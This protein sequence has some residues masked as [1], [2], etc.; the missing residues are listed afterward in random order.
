M[1]ELTRTEKNYMKRIRY[2]K[3]SWV[4]EMSVRR[5]IISITILFIL[6]SVMCYGSAKAAKSFSPAI[7]LLLTNGPYITFGPYVLGITDSTITLSVTMNENGTGYYLIRSTLETKPTVSQVMAGTYFHMTADMAAAQ[8]VTGLN[9]TTAYTLYFVVKNT[10]GIILDA[11]SSVAFK[12]TGAVKP[13]PL[14]D[15]GLKW[16][17]SYPTGNNSSCAGEEIGAQDCSHGR[18]VTHNDNSDG[19]AGFSYTKIDAAGNPLP[20]N[21]TNYPCV[22]DNVTGLIWELKTHD[23]GLHD[24]DDIYIWYSS[25]NNGGCSAS[26]GL[27][28]DTCKGYGDY[29][30]T[31]YCNTQAFVARV[32]AAG[33]C[34][35]S[36]WRMPTRKELSGILNYMPSSNGPHIEPLVFRDSLT[37]G[38]FWSGTPGAYVPSCGAWYVDFSKSTSAIGSR[39]AGR[40]IRLVRGPQ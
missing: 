3:G 14:N 37:G 27:Y 20:N 39:G 38:D 11:V 22:K 15:T 36:D 6:A 40:H 21:A 17:G 28:V 10:S 25:V 4:T 16:G 29:E 23:G 9:P 24:Y 12:T 34:G 13:K 26:D 35:A 8:I 7:Y 31:T 5:F 33:W 2:R 32:N 30:P 19:Y 18:D 1:F